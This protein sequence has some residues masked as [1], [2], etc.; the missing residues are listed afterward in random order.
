M[1][2]S[3]AKFFGNDEWLK[4]A[5][6]N[7]DFVLAAQ[8]ADGSWPYAKDG[9]RDFVDHFHTG[10]VMKALAKIFPAKWRSTNSRRADEGRGL[11]RQKSFRRRRHAAPVLESAALDRL[12]VRAL[13]LRRVHQLVRAAAQTISATAKNFGDRHRGSSEKVG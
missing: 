11:L 6:G 2:A 9:V 12:Q 5:A 7:V 4:I 10:F 1:L 13:R 3:A 8:N